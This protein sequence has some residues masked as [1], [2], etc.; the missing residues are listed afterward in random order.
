MR[1]LH[2]KNEVEKDRNMVFITFYIVT[3]RDAVIFACFEPA[4]ASILSPFYVGNT[5]IQI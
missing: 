2:I 4:L 3:N 1:Y 5:N